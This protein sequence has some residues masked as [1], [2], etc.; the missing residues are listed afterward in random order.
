MNA[1]FFGRWGKVFVA[2]TTLAAMGAGVSFFRFFSPRPRADS[3]VPLEKAAALSPAPDFSENFSKN[4]PRGQWPD[5]FREKISRGASDGE[6]LS[7][8]RS[9]AEADPAKALHGAETLGRTE[10]EKGKL[11]EAVMT[12]WAEK[13]ADGAWTWTWEQGSRL[14]FLPGRP[15][16][17]SVVMK[18]M[19]ASDPDALVAKAA[20]LL[21]KPG[22]AGWD[23]NYMTEIAAEALIQTGHADLAM[24]AVETWVQGS[25]RDQVSSD[26]LETV[27]QSQAVALSP[28]EAARW[29]ESLPACDGKNGALLARASAWAA[30]DP[31]A[32]LKW[33]QNL[34]EMREEGMRLVFAQWIRQDIRSAMDWLGSEIDKQKPNP[35]TDRLIALVV[36]DCLPE[37]RVA[38]LEWARAISNPAMREHAIG[39]GVLRWGDRDYAAAAAYVLQSDSFSPE[40]KQE[41][42]LGLQSRVQAQTLVR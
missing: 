4:K 39:Q 12:V 34:G 37:D 8:F 26:A 19:A 28:E 18:Q 11:L 7:L 3:P 9:W 14:Q 33:S 41:L 25:A 24:E 42:L 20:A 23:N 38:T 16:L 15:P 13:D 35:A 30:Q 2:G 5:L 17:L 27:A 6:I 40:K 36:S 10:E 29:L 32:A 22:S 21:Q 1:F 31:A